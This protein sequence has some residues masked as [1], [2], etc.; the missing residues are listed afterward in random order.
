M[1]EEII[2]HLLYYCIHIQDIWNQVQAYFTD[3][4]HFHGLSLFAFILLIILQL[5]NTGFYLLTNFENLERR[6]AVNNQNECE[7]FR[8]KWHKIENKIP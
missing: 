1:D 6:I 7:S 3:Y 5:E 8:K 2:R 4:L